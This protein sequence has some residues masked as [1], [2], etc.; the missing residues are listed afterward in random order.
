MFLEFK[1]DWDSVFGKG[2]WDSV[3]GKGDW[4]SVRVT[5]IV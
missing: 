1:G 5:G 3:F 2:D 4:D